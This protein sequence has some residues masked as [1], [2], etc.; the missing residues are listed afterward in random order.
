MKIIELQNLIIKQKPIDDQSKILTFHG[1]VTKHNN[2]N[3]P[4]KTVA[5]FENFDGDLLNKI[6]NVYD[7]LVCFLYQ[8]CYKF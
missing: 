1:F 4:L 5:D 8:I 3:L 2:Y 6:N 7:D